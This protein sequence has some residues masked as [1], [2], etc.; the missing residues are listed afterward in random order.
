MG[1]VQARIEL[2]NPREP[3][4]QPISTPALADTGA[5]MLCI[6]GHLALQLRREQQLER[7]V[8]RRQPPQP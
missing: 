3:D 6:P 5:L 4:L 2:N 8:T 1:Y 7:E